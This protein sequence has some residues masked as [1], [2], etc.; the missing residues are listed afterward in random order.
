VETSTA[1]T[2]A[3]YGALGVMASAQPTMNNLTFGNTQYQYYETIAG[4]AGAGEGFNGVS[5][6]QTLMTNSRLTDP[7]ILE[8][9]FPVR[10][11]EHRIRQGSG[12][13]GQWRGGEGA[14][15]ELRFLEPMTVNILSNGRQ[16]PAFG[17]KGG[18]AGLVGENWLIRE[19]GERQLL[20]S[21]THV[22][23]AAGEAIRILTP[24]GGGFGCP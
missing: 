14:E 9:R 8:T 16:V 4:G 1:I 19:N 2:N 23:V 20:P 17:L 15:R 10:V 6:T 18:K 22:D 12:G 13:Q 5:A 3:L 21:C 7:E 24:G 11:E